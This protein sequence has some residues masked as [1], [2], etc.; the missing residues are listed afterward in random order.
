MTTPSPEKIA[1]TKAETMRHILT[2]RSL[3]IGCVQE[4]LIRANLHDESKL[5]PPEDAAFAVLTPKLA[6]VEYGSKEYK[7]CL[8]EIKPAI[9]HHYQH[10]SHHP[11]HH[12]DGVNGM[13]LFNLLEMLVDWKA[14]GF[15]QVG[16]SMEKSLEINA[17]RFNMPKALVRLLENTLHWIDKIAE[18]T[19]VSVSY[20]HVESKKEE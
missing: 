8:H 20:P 9:E 11:Q 19:N 17:K 2:V 15:R 18:E 5:S 10:N 1:T 4:L 7:A 12:E 6:E 14:A 13:D 16:S 3:M